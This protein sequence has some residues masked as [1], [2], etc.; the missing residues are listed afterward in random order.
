MTIGKWA[1]LGFLVLLFV[2][3]GIGHFAETEAYV[4]LM[5][6]YLPAHRELVLVSGA[7]EILGGVGLMI[8]RLRRWAGIG[9]IA[10][11]VAVFPSNIYIA[12]NDVPVAGHDLPGWVHA[13]RLPLQGVLI[14]MTWWATRAR[15]AAKSRRRR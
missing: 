10:L 3:S 2:G 1:A 14:W 11:L 15:S 5:P 12:L 7:L 9:L 8:P 13:L 4:R 6:P